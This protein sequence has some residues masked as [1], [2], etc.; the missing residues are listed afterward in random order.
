M[1]IDPVT[2][3]LIPIIGPSACR[4]TKSYS[5]WSKSSLG[6]QTKFDELFSLD[7]SG[8][9]S[10]GLMRKSASWFRAF[11]I[12]VEIQQMVLA[13]MDSAEVQRQRFSRCSLKLSFTKRCRSNKIERQRF[14]FAK[15]I[16][17]WLCDDGIMKRNQQDGLC[18]DMTS[19]ELQWF[20]T[21]TQHKVSRRNVMKISSRSEEPAAKQLTI[22][23]ELSKLDVNC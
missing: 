14:A 11:C 15:K 16:S 10:T 1:G 22:Y 6:H 2:L 4:F 3:A 17:R 13:T 7:R 20:V 8:G 19:R 9:S 12:R 23:E 21:Q 18:D 5:F